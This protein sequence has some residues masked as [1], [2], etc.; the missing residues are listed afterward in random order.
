MDDKTAVKEYQY[1]ERAKSELILVSQLLAILAEL[2]D[3]ELTG[4]KRILLAMMDGVRMELEF[5]L[6]AT[7]AGEFQRAIN[8]LNGAISLV[9]SNQPGP[10]TLQVADAI[11]DAT[12]AAQEAWQV[13]SAHGLL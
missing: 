8:H 9:E 1:G 6:R 11:S 13:L 2:K 5:A 10:A 4:G 7:G 3:K 12:T